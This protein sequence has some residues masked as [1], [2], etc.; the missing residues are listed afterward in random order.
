MFTLIGVL[1][2]DVPSSKNQ[3][4]NSQSHKLAQKIAKH[5]LLKTGIIAQFL[6]KTGPFNQVYL[7]TIYS[8]RV[9]LTFVEKK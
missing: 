6:K 5:I 7:K 2:F 1:I 8:I 4:F 3:M 9:K